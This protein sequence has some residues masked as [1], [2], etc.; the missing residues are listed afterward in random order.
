MSVSA[1]YREFVLEQLS[2]VAPA[3]RGRSMFGGLGIY[4]NDLFFA[5]ADDDVLYFK[6]DDSNRA[7]FEA[8]GMGPFRPF[9]EDGEAMQYYEVPGDAIEDVDTLRQWVESA[10]AVAASKRKPG[11]RRRKTRTQGPPPK[12]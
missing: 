8:H 9:G 7:T 2:R 10:I 5:L 6:V 11:G 1:S 12:D 3:I 4:S